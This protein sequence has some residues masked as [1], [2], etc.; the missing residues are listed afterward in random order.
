[1]LVVCLV[2]LVAMRCSA[3]V[4]L[5]WNPS[6]SPGIAGYNVCWG[7]NSGIY[8]YTNNYLNTL[9]NAT[10]SDL[11]SN[12]VYFFAVQAVASNGL[13]SEFSNE[14][15]YTNGAPTNAASGPPNPPG[16]GGGITNTNPP[17]VVNT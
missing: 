14:E 15:G 6:T 2:E 7:T 9:T 8:I 10:I 17:I 11:V 12:Q 16:G 3:Q 5:T 4:T 1:A 13:T